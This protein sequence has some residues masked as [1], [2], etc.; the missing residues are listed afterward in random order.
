MRSRRVVQVFL[1]CG[2]AAAALLGCDRRAPLDPVHEG[3]SGV[4]VPSTTG[5]APAG[6][7][8]PLTIGNE[9][10]AVGE[11]HFR[12]EPPE[13][14][15]PAEDSIHSD[16]TRS[17][18]GTE[19]LFGRSYVVEKETTAQTGGS[20][21]DQP[22]ITVLWIRNRQDATGLYEADVAASV[23]PKLRDGTS[24][25]R[26][27]AAREHAVGRLPAPIPTN[28]PESQRGA[29]VA[30]WQRV[31]VRAEAV[32]SMVRGLTLNGREG[33]LQDNEITRLLYPMR[34]GISW[35]IRPDPLFTATVEAVEMLD[36][37][38]GRF[39]AYRLGI[40]FDDL[41][42]EE[43]VHVWYGR[44]GQLA[45]QYHLLGVVT[46]IDGNVIGKAAFDYEE[47]LRSLALV[48]PVT[49][50]LPG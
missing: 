1:L 47:V 48:G 21:G 43:F 34:P 49:A 24:S 13:P 7:F 31:Q 10:H 40:H 19:T 45:A 4:R 3:A 8:F 35:A 14:G 2:L 50:R 15:H 16:I 44:S 27:L 11:S 32:R 36:L 9:W 17:L 18:I 38:A 29:W 42:P 26:P 22:W 30:T 46:D 5:P 6:F 41:D 37:P 12:S 20:M 23:P 28:I 25:I 39:P 33:G